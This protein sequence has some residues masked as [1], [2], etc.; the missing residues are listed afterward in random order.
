M[1][2]MRKQMLL[3]QRA[4]F[5][6]TLKER[7]SFLAGKGVLASKVDKDTIVRKLKADIKAVNKRLRA[8]ADNDKKTEEMARIKAERAAAPKK[9]QEAGKTDKAKKAPEAGKAKKVKPEGG[10]SQKPAQ[11]P[12]EGKAEI[13]KKAE[14]ASEEPADQAK[15]AVKP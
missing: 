2:L 14:S 6:Q 12:A 13:K 3:Q 5:E 15:T 7:L 10:K 1:G 4:S 11:P 8:V 9:E